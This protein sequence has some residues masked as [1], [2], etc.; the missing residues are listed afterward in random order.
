[1]AYTESQK[2]ATNK[3]IKANYDRINI[4][5]PIGQR[6]VWRAR[7]EELGLSL[8]EFIRVCVEKNL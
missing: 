4:T 2:K 1:M 6:E 3:W 7:A 8:N 5:L